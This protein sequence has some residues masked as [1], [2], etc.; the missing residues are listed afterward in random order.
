MAAV[1][2]HEN[3]IKAVP[4]NRKNEME[5]QLRSEFND[6]EQRIQRQLDTVAAKI[7]DVDARTESLARQL[8]DMQSSMEEMR[9]EL[10]MANNA[11]QSP[12]PAGICFQRK[13]DG[14][15]LKAVAPTTV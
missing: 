11:P 6:L 14:T 9:K 8:A 2:S 12:K 4:G 13:I 7:N 1:R 3:A 10:A 15:I 5:T